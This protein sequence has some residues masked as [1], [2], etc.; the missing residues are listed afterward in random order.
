MVQ[1][2]DFLPEHWC[3]CCL[4][5]GTYLW[6]FCL[7][8]LGSVLVAPQV[9]VQEYNL[10]FSVPIKNTFKKCVIQQI[11]IDIFIVVCGFL[12]HQ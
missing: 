6:F 10:V 5:H 3:H 2:Q 4:L 9:Q 11:E 7:T 12:K 1:K 8:G